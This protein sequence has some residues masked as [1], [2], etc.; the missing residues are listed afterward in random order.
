M[1]AYRNHTLLKKKFKEGIL[2]EKWCKCYEDVHRRRR[3]ILLHSTYIWKRQGKEIYL[4]RRII[5]KKRKEVFSSVL[6]LAPT[7]RHPR[8]SYLR[9]FFQV[10]FLLSVWHVETLP[11]LASLG[12]LGQIIPNQRKLLR[13]RWRGTSA[14]PACWAMWTNPAKQLPKNICTGPTRAAKAG[15]KSLVPSPRNQ[16]RKDPCRMYSLSPHFEIRYDPPWTNNIK[17]KLHLVFAKFYIHVEVGDRACLLIS[18]ENW[19]EHA[20]ITV[21][22]GGKNPQ[23]C[24]NPLFLS[25][26]V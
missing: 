2:Y 4:L 7:N 8:A 11:K 10:F 9:S 3:L 16:P 18:E 26:T 12:S 19:E 5:E 13:D 25:T 21:H 6:E 20:T 17:P 24:F 23:K 22:H 1:W 14:C 15:H